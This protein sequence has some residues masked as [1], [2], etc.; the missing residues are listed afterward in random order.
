M[1]EHEF[2]DLAFDMRKKQRTFFSDRS[3]QNL[4][5]AK[6]AEKKFDAAIEARQLQLMREVDYD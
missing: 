4:V 6:D 3:K 5:A 1:T 2:L